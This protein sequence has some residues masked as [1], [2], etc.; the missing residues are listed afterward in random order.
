MIDL[1]DPD[2]AT[3]KNLLSRHLPDCKFY[4]FGSRVRGTAH[5]FS[6]LDIAIES[7]RPIET[8]LLESL[9]DAL[10][11]S[12]LPILVDLVDLSKVGDTFRKRIDESKEPL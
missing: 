11:E 2:R 3:V 5:R 12:D 6:D 1:P 10:S 9:R 4:A 7:D 8:R